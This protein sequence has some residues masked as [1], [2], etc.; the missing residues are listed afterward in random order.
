[1]SL[2]VLK[3]ELAVLPAIE[4]SQIMAYLLSLQDEQDDAYRT[5]LARKIDEKDPHRWVSLEE[6]DHRL[7]NKKD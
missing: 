3:Q 7:A 5:A 1:M 6:L 2:D 4:R